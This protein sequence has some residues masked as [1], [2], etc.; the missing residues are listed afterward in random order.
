[1]RARLSWAIALAIA[2]GTMVGVRAAQA[3]GTEQEV[4]C[5]V[6]T[7]AKC[8]SDCNGHPG[9]ECYL[10]DSKATTPPEN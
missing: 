6:E 9:S 7:D 1:M 8:W 5:Q 3:T 4:W 2:L 10:K